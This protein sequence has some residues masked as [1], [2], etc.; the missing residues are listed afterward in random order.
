M[1]GN[2]RK[3]QT[4]KGD[5]RWEIRV[6]TGRDP[7]TGRR[8]QKSQTFTT[9]AGAEAALNKALERLT[10][11]TYV[12]PSNLTVDDYLLNHWLPMIESSVRPTTWESYRAAVEQWIIPNVGRVRLQ[13][14]TALQ[15]NGMYRALAEKP[16][17]ST[18]VRYAHT[19]LRKA[20][21]DALRKDLVVR[22]VADAAD[23]P[24]KKAV[25]RGAEKAW[26]VEHARAFL[27]HVAGDRYYAAWLLSVTTGLRRGE[28]LGLAWGAL[29]LDSGSLVVRQTLSPI[30]GKMHF[31]EPK[32]ASSRRVI[33]LPPVAV[34]A[35][36]EHRRKQLEDRMAIGAGY[37]PH[38][39]VFV[40]EN[41][42]PVKPER[43]TKWFSQ[44]VKAAEL[45]PLPLHGL[46][47]THATIGLKTG[48]DVKVMSARL[49]HSN[50][51]ITQ[52][53]YQHVLPGMDRGAA[54]AIADAI[55]GS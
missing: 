45:P 9:R 35:L 5:P 13:Q 48:Q 30:R 6:D 1:R 37:N 4:V 50:T 36:R 17:S 10:D 12:N 18:T 40:Y 11:Q 47:H 25:S 20:L 55:L 24:R 38:D 14:L 29:D 27:E 22:N 32:T 2:I 42:S 3:H 26:D 51:A 33:D 31:G 39:L 15:L 23:P 44:H 54:D 53:V 43:L 28:L 52:D 34:T 19:I 7:K 41:G 49:G 21:K 46:R 16:L 8:V